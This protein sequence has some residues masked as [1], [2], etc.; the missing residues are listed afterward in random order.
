[1]YVS[2]PVKAIIGK[3]HF[4]RRKNLKDLKE[5]FD[6][7]SEV[8]KRIEYYAKKH[9]YVMEILDVQMTETITLETRKSNKG[10]VCTQVYYYLN[11]Y[12]DLFTYIKEN[13]VILSERKNIFEG[14]NE[15]D[16]DKVYVD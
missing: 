6:G 13:E 3:I 9:K 5:T 2:Y 4:G 16:I 15:E 12:Q 8:L 10:F 14:L 11:D 7:H 1:M